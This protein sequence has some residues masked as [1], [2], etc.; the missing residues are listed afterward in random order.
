MTKE[1]E[2]GK[3]PECKRP[4]RAREEG[5]FGTFFES[6]E[7]RYKLLEGEF[8]GASYAE[9]LTSSHPIKDTGTD[10]LGI[11]ESGERM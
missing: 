4:Q 10:E 3:T 6:L 5:A 2:R 8:P 1:E 9:S 11:N 7:C